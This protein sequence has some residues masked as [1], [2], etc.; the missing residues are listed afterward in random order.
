MR[1]CGDFITQTIIRVKI[2]SSPIKQYEYTSIM[3][4][5]QKITHFLKKLGNMWQWVLGQSGFLAR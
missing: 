3:T 4:I 1:K 2:Y 5:A